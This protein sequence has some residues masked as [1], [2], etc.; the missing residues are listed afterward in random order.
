ML[1]LVFARN[2]QTGD[3]SFVGVALSPEQEKEISNRFNNKNVTCWTE[4]VP[5]DGWSSP[6]TPDSH[7]EYVYL[8]FRGGRAQNPETPCT[9]GTYDPEILGAFLDEAAA[10]SHLE[11]HPYSQVFFAED[12][13]IWKV[14]GKGWI[15]DCGSAI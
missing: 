11:K 9:E 1:K 14:N 10:R 6:L 7:P 13:H 3:E 12:F 2:D 4:T 5:L 15:S 8:L